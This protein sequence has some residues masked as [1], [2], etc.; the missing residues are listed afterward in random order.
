MD[1]KRLRT[2]VVKDNFKIPLYTTAQY[3]LLFPSLSLVV[4]LCILSNLAQV[5]YF[6]KHKIIHFIHLKF[7]F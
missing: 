7:I 5:S 2:Y 4:Y 1:L 3:N 6:S